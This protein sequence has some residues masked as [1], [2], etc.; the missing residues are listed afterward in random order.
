MLC[1]KNSCTGC[2]SCQNI[3]PKN[4]IQV[5]TDKQGFWQP[6]I[7]KE[8]CINC[9]LCHKSCPVYFKPHNEENL[10]EIYACW[11]KNPQKRQQAASGGLF[12]ALM[13]QALSQ[14]F[15]VCGSTLTDDLKAKHIIINKIEDYPLLI[16]SKYVQSFIGTTYKDIRKLLLQGEKYYF[17]VHLVKLLVYMLFSKNAI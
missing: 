4:A 17:P 15:Y 9:G 2:L 12:T 5:I 14:N 16:G 3:C 7:D 11:H 1:S 10:T 6:Q 8:K 13:L